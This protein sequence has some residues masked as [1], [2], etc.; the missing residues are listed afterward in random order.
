[1]AKLRPCGPLMVSW[2]KTDWIGNLVHDWIWIW[3]SG[4]FL[5]F[6]GWEIIAAELL[7]VFV[8][9][10]IILGNSCCNRGL[11]LSGVRVA[12]PEKK[13]GPCYAHGLSGSPVSRGWPKIMLCHLK[14]SNLSNWWPLKSIKQAFYVYYYTIFGQWEDTKYIPHQSA[15]HSL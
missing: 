4:G 10:V 7:S 5:E 1:M 15:M 2:G 3:A 14:K 12:E 9:A 13:S 8:F 11:V 6:R